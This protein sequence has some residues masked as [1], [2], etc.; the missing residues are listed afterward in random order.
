MIDDLGGIR[1][2]RHTELLAAYVVG[3]TKERIEGCG[4]YTAIISLHNPVMQD[5]PGEP[6]RMVPPLQLLTHVSQAKIRKWE[7]SFGTRWTV[8][9]G[10]LL[11]KLVEEELGED[12]TQSAAKTSTGGQQ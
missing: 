6:S 7:E 5:T 11:D 12:A 4:K 3:V 9:Q 2:I 8:R 10:E 1:D